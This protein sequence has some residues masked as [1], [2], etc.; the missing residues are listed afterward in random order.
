MSDNDRI[1]ALEVRIATLETVPPCACPD[2]QASRKRR[3]AESATLQQLAIEGS[4]DAIAK[5]RGMSPRDQA[6]FW[7]RAADERAIELLISPDVTDEERARWVPIKLRDRIELE[8]IELPD[9][10]RVRLVA[11][12][13]AL[14]LHPAIFQYRC[15]LIN[16]LGNRTD[17]SAASDNSVILRTTKLVMGTTRCVFVNEYENVCRGPRTQAPLW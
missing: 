7:Q 9:R 3:I 13:H 15:S 10:V 17:E 1:T 14:Q 8:L 11:E 5:V 12:K 6:M 4:P 16:D 2:C